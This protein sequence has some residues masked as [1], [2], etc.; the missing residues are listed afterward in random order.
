MEENEEKE[1]MK[2]LQEEELLKAKKAKKKNGKDLT[3]KKVTPETEEVCLYIPVQALCT[4]SKTCLTSMSQ[5]T[6]GQTVFV[7]CPVQ[8]ASTQRSSPPSNSKE[9]PQ[10]TGQPSPSAE[11][12]FNDPD[13]RKPNIQSS[14]RQIIDSSTSFLFLVPGSAAPAQKKEAAHHSHKQA[15]EDPVVSHREAT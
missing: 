4:K 6:R 7:S 1:R 10:Q 2:R 15:E 5:L 9:L 8:P 13:K 14:I 3:K 12:A 11:G